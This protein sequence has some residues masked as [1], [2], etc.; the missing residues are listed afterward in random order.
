MNLL[1]VLLTFALIGGGT[2]GL[3][4]GLIKQAVSLGSLYIALVVATISYRLTGGWLSSTFGHERAASE[5]LSF[6]VILAF[7]YIGLM[8]AVSDLIKDHKR[9]PPGMID[10]LGGMALGFFNTGIWVAIALSLL[11]STLVF[12]WY[13]YDPLRQALRHQIQ[14]SSL[15]P[16]FGYLL[17]TLLVTVRPFLPGGLP[18]LFTNLIF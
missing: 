2:L 7:L 3:F 15:R 10:R 6:M 12:S 16:A 5:A 17:P 11:N 13:T 9:N 8:V 4:Q 18:T 1:D 14:T